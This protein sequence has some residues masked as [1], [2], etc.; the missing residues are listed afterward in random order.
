M[1]I[2]LKKL[3]QIN[4]SAPVVPSI[5]TSIAPSTGRRRL[6]KDPVEWSPDFER[7]RSLSRRTSIEL[8]N[9]DHLK[10]SL[11]CRCAEFKRPCPIEL[12]EVQQ[13]TLSEVK[14]YGGALGFIGAGEGKTLIDVL[15]AMVMPECKV[16]VL[17]L[18][19]D[20]RAQFLDIDW[21]LYGAHWKLPNL[22]GGRRFTPG[23]PLIHVVTYHELQNEKAAGLL[24]AIRPDTFIGDEV[25]NL[26]SASGPRCTRFRRYFEKYPATRFAGW[27]GSLTKR[28]LHDFAHLSEFALKQNSP[29]PL[30]ESEVRKWAAA[31][32][33]GV[34]FRPDPGVLAEFGL[35]VREGF[36]KRLLETPGVVGTR[37]NALDTSLV[38]HERKVDVPK[39]VT[40]MLRAVRGEKKRP[41][42]EEL[43]TPMDVA[44]SA[45]EVACG[46]Y[47]RWRWVKGETKQIQTDWLFYRS[48]WHRE[49][50]DMLGKPRE[51]LDSPLLLTKAA[52]RWYNGGCS[53][54]HRE[55]LEEH[56][57]GCENAQTALLWE[58]DCWL[59]WKRVRETAQ[60]ITE[61][62][63]VDDFLVNDAADWG[64]KNVGIIWYLHDAYGKR[65]HEVSEFPLFGAGAEASSRILYEKGDRTI[66]A[67]IRA[68]GTGKNLQSYCRNLVTNM[69]SDGGIHEQLIARTHRPGQLADEVTVTFYRHTP[70]LREALE[71]ARDYA[72]YIQGV[73]GN[74]QRLLY[75]DYSFNPRKV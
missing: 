12:R 73:S 10:Q 43:I 47:Y 57:A 27:S 68:Q 15:T 40:D 49:L 39:A 29:L 55:A 6:G 21:Y 36:K 60:P 62:V 1:P 23:R 51:H 41:D 31:I 34:T 37:E 63:W 48:L 54:C 53:V 42:G 13:Q 7:V 64:R 72:A 17:L 30:K 9:F 14:Q 59:D 11:P 4:G 18:P 65:L 2:D 69:P 24:E 44:K 22:A 50:R 46:F 75:G 33:P 35:P 19:A 52:I 74:S 67:S 45:R 28:S 32:D 5:Q 56:A 71:S 26:K 3:R 16:A 38:F 70:E 58:S 66:I 20:L 8:A 25:Q 61:P